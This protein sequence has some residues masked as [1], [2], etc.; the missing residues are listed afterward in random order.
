[1]LHEFFLVAVGHDREEQRLHLLVVQLAFVLE[2]LH[3][4]VFAENRRLGHAQVKVR[5]AFAHKGSQQRLHR[6][7]R[8]LG[9]LRGHLYA[10]ARRARSRRVLGRELHRRRAEHAGAPRKIAFVI[11]DDR[12]VPLAVLQHRAHREHSLGAVVAELGRRLGF[13]LL[14]RSGRGD[15]LEE[16]NDLRAGQH[17]RD[18]LLD[19]VDFENRAFVLAEE[20]FVGTVADHHV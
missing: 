7:F 1:M 11:D 15:F 14:R 10:L 19:I 2:A 3:L 6:F 4:A 17:F 8:F 12:H 13:D 16:R 5:R 20:E 9:L 18:G